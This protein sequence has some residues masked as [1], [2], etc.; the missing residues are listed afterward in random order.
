MG[1]EVS[2]VELDAVGGGVQDELDVLWF[3][4]LV[5]SEEYIGQVSALEL[6]VWKAHVVQILEQIRGNNFVEGVH[7]CS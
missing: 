1:S 6:L 3:G 7:T 4:G 2:G 5:K